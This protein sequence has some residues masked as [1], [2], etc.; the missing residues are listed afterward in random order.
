MEAPVTPM[1]KLDTILYI[2]SLSPQKN[3]GGIQQYLRDNYNGCDLRVE[4]L[5][6]IAKR[7][8]KDEYIEYSLGAGDM[9]TI[10]FDGELFLQMG[11]YNSKA[12]ADA[13]DAEE[14]RLEIARLKYVD[15]SSDLN[16]KTLNTLTGRLVRATWFAFG[17]A[18]A[19]LAWQ[20][21]STYNPATN[22]CDALLKTM[23]KP[24]K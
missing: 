1:D 12:L 24:K 20:I 3:I 10:T 16:Q 13:A 11:G 8:A 17:A 22:S 7:L 5:R 18:I 14:Q 21:Y 23:T 15:V 6:K 2:L 19:L 9:C 4:E